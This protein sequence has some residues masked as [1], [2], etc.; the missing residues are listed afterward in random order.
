VLL[1]VAGAQLA[2]RYGLPSVSWM[3]TDSLD[4]DAQN[5]LEKMLA[6]VAHV[7]AGVSTIWGV[8]Q[9]ES[10]K[11]LS[12]AQAVID[13]EI[14]GMVRH[15]LRGFPVDDASLALA[16]VRR[17]GICGSFLDSEHTFAHF[18]SVL[19]MPRL[20]VRV[21]RMSAPEGPSLRAR[22]EERVE[23]ILAEV[24]EPCL[25]REQERELL[26]IERRFAKEG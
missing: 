14:A 5:A 25:S 8:G 4:Y 21:Q 24:P 18:R 6:A 17:A 3:C 7:Q 1:A 11:T 15:T 26:A 23:K 10:E 13:D 22:A 16:E 19:F 20:L 9:V 2:R 12:P